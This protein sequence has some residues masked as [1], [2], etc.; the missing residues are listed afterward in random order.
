MAAEGRILPFSAEPTHPGVKLDK[1]LSYRRQLESLKKKINNTR[2]SFEAPS[3]IK[4]GGWCQN[5]EHSYLGLDPL[6]CRVLCSYLESKCSHAP[7][8][9]AH[10]RRFAPGCL[11]PTPTDNL[12]A[13]S[14]ITPTELRRKRA[15]LSLGCR[16]QE[17]GHLLHDRLTSHPYGG[18][19]PLKSRHPLCMLFWNRSE[20]QAN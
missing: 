19:R 18:H 11:R 13:L 6:C 10:Q 16:A 8:R 2:W 4:L 7:N 3:R 1:S 5:V 15:T 9:Q 12:F 20:I 17:P 14:G